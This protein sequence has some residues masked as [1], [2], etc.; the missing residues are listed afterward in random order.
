MAYM[1]AE[2]KAVIAAAVKPVLNKYGLKGTLSVGHHS[3]IKL[4]LTSGPIDFIAN[5]NEVS[6]RN[7]Y[8][9][10]NGGRNPMPNTSGYDDVNVYWI[11]EHYD[12]VA[13]EA[14]Q[15]LHTALKAAGWYDNTRSEIDYFDTAYYC[16]IHVGRWQ[17][18]Y[19]VTA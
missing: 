12:G 7:P 13:R 1:N 16:S 5:S 9:V 17:K 6:A 18:P 4:T 11:H 3:T 8:W 10:L 14:L 19:Q 15:E 2:K